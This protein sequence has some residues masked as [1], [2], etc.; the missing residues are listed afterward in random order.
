MRIALIAC[1]KSKRSE[2]SPAGDLYTG[3]LFRK[4]RAWAQAHCDGFAILSAEFGLLQPDVITPPYER[5]LNTMPA[6][7]RRA[8]GRKVLAQVAIAFPPG[9]TFVVLAGEHYRRPFEQSD[10]PVEFPLKGLKGLGYQKQ[11]LKENT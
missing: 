6:I 7:E 3:D 10:L 2:P 11:W 1:C 4:A 5:T 9:T 8:W